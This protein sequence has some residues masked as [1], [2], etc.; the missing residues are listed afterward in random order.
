MDDFEWG[1]E[2]QMER[3]REQRDEWDGVD[4]RVSEEDLRELAE[5]EA[6]LEAERLMHA[7]HRAYL[8]RVSQATELTVGGARIRVD[9]RGE[10]VGEWVPVGVSMDRSAPDA[11]AARVGDALEAGDFAEVWRL[12]EEE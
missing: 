5:L 8:R 7:I 12:C 1:R 2:R 9:S 10:K 11:W 4:V 6:R 3:E